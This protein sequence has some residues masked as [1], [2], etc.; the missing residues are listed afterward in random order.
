M[1]TALTWFCLFCAIAA[2][3]IL[4]M[5]MAMPQSGRPVL[6]I[7]GLAG[8]DRHRLVAESGGYPLG[9]RHPPLAILAASQDP[10]FARRLRAA[11]AWLVLD[12]GRLAALCG[13][14]S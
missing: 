5:A 4:A 3:P 14:R 8:A 2:P 9:P 7:S 11:G 13:V 1:Q 6:V 12:A 10:A